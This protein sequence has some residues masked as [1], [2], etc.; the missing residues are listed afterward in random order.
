MSARFAFCRKPACFRSRSIFLFSRSSHWWS[1]SS[2]R[3][4]SHVI[5]SNRLSLICWWCRWA[6]APKR[7]AFNFSIVWLLFI[8]FNFVWWILFVC[9]GTPYVG[10]DRYMGFCGLRVEY[11][12]PIHVVLQDVLYMVVRGSLSLK[13]SFAGIVESFRPIGFMELDDPHGTFV[14]YFRII[15]GDQYSFH[16]AQYM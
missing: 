3:Y 9:G 13:R 1:V 4:S 14:T 6:M 5:A 10:V 16:A 12:R 11:R 7:I 15:M 8:V 2:A